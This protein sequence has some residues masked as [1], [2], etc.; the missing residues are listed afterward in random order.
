MTLEEAI[1]ILRRHN[2]T[3]TS[4]MR[5]T[6]GKCLEHDLLEQVLTAYERILKDNQS[7]RTLL[8][9]AD[10]DFQAIAIANSIAIPKPGELIPPGG[11]G[12]RVGLG[13]IIDPMTLRW[14]Y[15]NAVSD[16]SKEEDYNA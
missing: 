4:V 12:Q 1:K 6:G 13:D 7:M 16:F 15:H 9:K 3:G 8:K 2:Q 5:I 14:R 10:M 11:F